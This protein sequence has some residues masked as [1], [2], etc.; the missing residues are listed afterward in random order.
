MTGRTRIGDLLSRDEIRALTQRSN[1]WGAWAVG[2]TWAVLG[3]TFAALAWA[4]AHLPGWAFALALLAGLAIVAGRQLCLGILQHD[5][6][7]SSLFRSKWCNDVLVDWLCARPIWNELHKY[8]P[9]HLTHHARTATEDDPDLCLVAAFPTTRR[10]LARKFARDLLGVSG[11]KFLVG[12][13]LMDAGVLSWSL[14]GDTRRL[15]QDGRAWWD[16]PRTFLRNAGGMLIANGV[17][18]ALFCA[19]GQGWLYGVWV[20]AYVT[21]FPLFIR[22]RSLAEHACLEP[23]AD[24]LKNTRSTRAGWIA[25]ACVAPIRVNYHIEHHLM[26]SVPYFRLPLL[27]RLLRDRGLVGAPPSYLAVLRQVSSAG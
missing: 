4:R 1:R 22:I 15:P 26:A 18:A 2:S 3:L 14:T 27:H 23:G 17:L 9:Y 21:P 12:R 13:A 19:F 8:R 16:Y 11:L 7:H 5:A 25:R 24:V 10:S 6:A 20:L